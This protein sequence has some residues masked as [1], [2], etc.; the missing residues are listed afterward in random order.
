MMPPGP[1]QHLPTLR[2]VI[3][4]ALVVFAGILKSLLE[5]QL[6]FLGDSW[7]VSDAAA[8]LPL[9]PRAASACHSAQAVPGTL[10][11]RAAAGAG[12]EWG[13]GPDLVTASFSSSCSYM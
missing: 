12:T 5:R 9:W 3:V 7:R 4:W 11:P 1:A 13:C 2:L 10:R 6:W 8:T